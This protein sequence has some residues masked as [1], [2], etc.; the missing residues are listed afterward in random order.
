MQC[1]KKRSWLDLEG[2]A[3]HLGDAPGN[4]ESVERFERKDIQDEHVK[5]AL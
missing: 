1:W 2:I 3:S 5:R 4:A